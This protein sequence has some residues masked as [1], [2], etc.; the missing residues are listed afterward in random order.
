M[1]IFIWVVIFVLGLIVGY[2]LK[3]FLFHQSR[4]GGTIYVTHREEKTLYSLV[5]DEY[6]ES[7]EFKKEIVFKVDALGE[8][9][10]RE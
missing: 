3:S 2:L 4:Y 1:E 8:E 6:P 7:L 10:H 9:S 5:L